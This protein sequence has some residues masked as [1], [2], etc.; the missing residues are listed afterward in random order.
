MLEVLV[1]LVVFSTVMGALLQ[2]VSQ[3]VHALGSAEREVELTELARTQV[4]SVR[5]EAAAGRSPELGVT[6]G[7]F[8]EP[9]EHMRWELSVESFRFPLPEGLSRKKLVEAEKRSQMFG[10]AESSPLHL[11]VLRVFDEFGD[12]AIDPF[13]ILTAD[14]EQPPGATGPQ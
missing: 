9:W 5:A 6:E 10:E 13:V 11:V 14:T 8:D 12:E 4:R 1:A 2:V 3:N 7:E